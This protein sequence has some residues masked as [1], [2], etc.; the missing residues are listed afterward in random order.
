[1]V[2][3]TKAEDTPKPAAEP[4]KVEATEPKKEESK[5]AEVLAASSVKAEKKEEEKK[6]EVK[7]R[8][9]YTLIVESMDRY[10]KKE[11]KNIDIM[12]VIE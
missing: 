8:D 5:P 12:F 9:Y 11:K 4:P 10:K 1:M 2:V 6:P 3:G 7:W